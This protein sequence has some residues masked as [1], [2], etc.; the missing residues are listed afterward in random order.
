MFT[1]CKLGLK[2]HDPSKVR[3]VVKL[4]PYRLGLDPLMSKTPTDWALGREWDGDVLDNDVLGNCGPVAVVNLLN[5]MAVACGQYSLRFTVQDVLDLYTAFGYDGTPETDN[6]V[7]LLDLL[8]YMQKVGIRGFRFDCFFRVGFADAEHLATAVAISP[9]IVGASLT[10]ACQTTDTWGTGVAYDAHKWGDH[11][12]LIHAWSP[13]GANGKSWGAPVF[14][15]PEFQ[16]AKWNEC[17][18]P[19]CRQLMP[20]HVDVD[21]LISL[22]GQL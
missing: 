1:N 3:Q 8:H 12:Y 2:P 4:L 5:M 15:T 22:A 18:L 10:V 6:G 7:V 19:I 17:Y 9:L 16:T 11:A 14:T 20:K 21:R 13:G